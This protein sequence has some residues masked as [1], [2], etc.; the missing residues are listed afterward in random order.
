MEEVG[1]VNTSKTNI[2]ITITV[3]KAIIIALNHSLSIFTCIEVHDLPQIANQLMYFGEKSIPSNSTE[4]AS[5]FRVWTVRHPYK[6]SFTNNMI[7][8]YKTPIS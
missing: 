7:F 8:G 3:I 6:N 4:K 5:F 1:M 2:L